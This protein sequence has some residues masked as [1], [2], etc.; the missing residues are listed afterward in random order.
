MYPVSQLFSTRG[1]DF[2]QRGSFRKKGSLE[3][4]SS[5]LDR[6]SDS[7]LEEALSSILNLDDG[8]LEGNRLVLLAALRN[9]LLRIVNMLSVR[10]LIKYVLS[11]LGRSI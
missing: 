10:T 2:I 3:E 9:L 7:D 6:L 1:V 11:M 4:F 5:S 8:E